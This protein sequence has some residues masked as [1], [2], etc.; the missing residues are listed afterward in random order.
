MWNTVVSR[1]RWSAMALFMSLSG[2]TAL[3][4][5][6]YELGQKIRTSQAWHDFDGCNEECFTGDYK[7]G[8]KAGYYDVVTGGTGMPPVIAPRKYWKPPV[9]CE[10]DP[11]RRDE[12]YCGFQ[13]GA[14]CAKCQP[15]YHY[16]QTF[17]P[18]SPGC[19]VPQ[20]S[21]SAASR[22]P[23]H[24]SPESSAAEVGA[25]ASLG[26]LPGENE[27]PAV[28]RNQAPL[29]APAPE[30]PEQGRPSKNDYEKDPEPLPEPTSNNA[31]SVADK[32]L[33]ERIVN[34][35][36][37][38]SARPDTLLDQLVLNASLNESHP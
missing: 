5:C 33:R 11:S 38:R 4:D 26:T 7:S 29:A 17:L 32:I 21:H 6:K 30:L 36:R 35:V 18:G 3:C 37:A 31:K 9:F 25:P 19:P 34:R 12:W 23:A 28:E 2:C 13:D 14:A 20:I 10:H 22:P 8:W 1:G 24:L 16:L 15:D 27:A